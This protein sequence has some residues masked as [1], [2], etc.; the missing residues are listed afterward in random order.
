ME[1]KNLKKPICI[2]L[3]AILV[4]QPVVLVTTTAF[5]NVAV[6]SENDGTL[7]VAQDPGSRIEEADLANHVPIFIN[8]SAD[9]VDQ[10][11]PGAG[12]SGDPYVISGLL[13]HYVLATPLVAIYNVDDYFVIRDCF[14]MQNSTGRALEFINTTHGSIEYSEVYSIWDNAILC[15]N[16]NQTDID[17]VIAECYN[18]GYYSTVI[19]ESVN[20]DVSNSRIRNLQSSGINVVRSDYFNSF[21]T[22]YSGHDTQFSIRIFETN[23][24]S[25]VSDSVGPGGT[26]VIIN[27]CNHSSFTGLRGSPDFGF[28][29]TGCHELE[30]D[31]ADIGV[32]DQVLYAELCVNVN[33][34][35]SVFAGGSDE[36]LVFYGCNSSYISNN[37]FIGNGDDGLYI[38]SCLWFNIMDN[39]L[40]D[41][42]GQGIRLEFAHFTTIEGNDI[43][44]A[45]ADGINMAQCNNT[46]IDSN[47]IDNPTTYPIYL[48]HAYHGEITKNDIANRSGNAGLVF[49]TYCADWLVA[50]NT[51]D[52]LHGG[53]FTSA[54]CSNIKVYRN[55]FSNMQNMFSYAVGIQNCPDS[56]IINN[57]AQDISAWGFYFG[58]GADRCLVEGNTVTNVGTGINV[59][60]DNVTIYNNEFLYTNLYGIWIDSFSDNVDINENHFLHPGV[61]GIL[62]AQPTHSKIRNNIFDGGAVGIFGTLINSTIENNNFTGCGI[63]LP[64]GETLPYYYHTISGNMVNGKPFYYTTDANGVS[65]DGDQ[66]GQIMLVNSTNMNVNGGDFINCSSSIMMYY[67]DEVDVTD[68]FS[69]YNRYSMV[70]YYS[71]NVTVTDSI[72]RD[73]PDI[74]N[75]F[76]VLF[77]NCEDI[78]V[79]NV[80]FNEIPESALKIIASPDFTVLDSCFTNIGSNGL[81]LQTS[82]F[83]LVEN[84]EF[85]NVETGIYFYGADDSL[86]TSNLF[87][88]CTVGVYAQSVADNIN[89]TDSSF[90]DGWYGLFISGADGW[91]IVGNDIMWNSWYGIYVATGAP[92]N[93]SLNVLIGNAV[94]GYDGNSVT[95]YWDDQVSTGNYWSDYT[96]PAPSYLVSGGANSEDRFPMNAF[97]AVTGPLISSPEDFSY[98]EFSEGNTVTWLVF[99]DYMRD[100]EVYVDSVLIESD[101]W[102]FE[103][104]SVIIDGLGYGVHEIFVEARD[105]D[106]NYVND[107]VLVTVFDDTDPTINEPDNVIVFSGTTGNEIAWDIADQNPDRLEVYRDDVLVYSGGWGSSSWTYTYSLD[108][109]AEGEYSFRLA[110][111]DADDNTVSDFVTV[112]VLVDDIDPIISHPSDINMTEGTTGNFIVWTAT[113]TNPSHFAVS[114]NNTVF[115][116]GGWGGTSVI[117]AIDGLAEGYYTFTVTVYDAAGNIATDAVNV[118]VIPVGGWLPTPLPDFTLIIVAAIA[119]IGIVAIV[120]VVVM[121]KK[122]AGSV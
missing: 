61:Y 60:A 29:M 33:I 26:G 87:R 85:F 38:D 107:T 76:G 48:D 27:Y 79:Q 31:S 40:T 65:L 80:T 113:D 95:N 83:G 120:I 41:I 82:Q 54:A 47:R 94:N 101:A 112:Y 45:G 14:I 17:H 93:I 21:S 43:L 64:H 62:G 24:A 16:A 81:Y 116:E 37:E 19:L 99:D 3:L 2:V 118:T 53:V 63:Y 56:E 39:V 77:Q 55:S 84:C 119:A 7:V 121:R 4:L 115:A 32:E 109:L 11:W 20:V 10:G 70:I 86:A 103:N 100:W 102:N 66:Y 25:S 92:A 13:I 22:T 18:V 51:F 28:S 46:I 67:C 96:P 122:K 23:H 8:S 110:V 106:N 58:G 111:Y 12:T 73:A 68:T 104:I 69:Q 34:T 89:I 15:F 90:L 9:F 74:L 91:N 59:L 114:E 117:I 49:Q 105:Y 72:V 30:I 1:E 57:T 35:N 6:S 71:T 44:D 42:G 97:D 50:D 78:L 5:G 108:G 88:W 52:T 98:A 36:F 75:T